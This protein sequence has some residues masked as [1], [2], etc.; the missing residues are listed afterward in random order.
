MGSEII[1]EPEPVTND[2]ANTNHISPIRDLDRVRFVL[3]KCHIPSHMYAL[4]E[5][6]D[7]RV[8][9]FCKDGQWLVTN[10]ERG[11]RQVEVRCDDIDSAVLKFFSELSGTRRMLERMKRYWISTDG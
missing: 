10:V 9:L 3:R 5:E 11:N 8:N 7:E 2:V 6:C 1:V 4:G